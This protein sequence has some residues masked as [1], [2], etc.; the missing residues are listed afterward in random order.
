MKITREDAE[1]LNRIVMHEGWAVL[2]RYME[3]FEKH[4][5]RQLAEEHFTDLLAVGRLQGQITALR[6]FRTFVERRTMD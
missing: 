6:K 4:W 2:M 3:E 5:S 1:K